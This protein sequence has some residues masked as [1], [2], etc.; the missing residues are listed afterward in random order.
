L[1]IAE[2]L[3]VAAFGILCI[4]GDNINAPWLLFEAGALAKKL[5]NPNVCPY[6]IH[7]KP[8]D[9]Q[10]PLSQFQACEATKAETRKLVHSINRAMSQG[11]LHEDQ[12]DRSFEKWWDDL[13]RALAE[14]Q[15]IET[16]SPLRTEKDLLEELIVRVRRLDNSLLSKSFGSYNAEYIMAGDNSFFEGTDIEQLLRR[17]SELNT[18]TNFD[19][20]TEKLHDGYSHSEIDGMWSTAWNGGIVGEKWAKGVAIVHVFRGTFYAITDDSRA[21]CLIGA[22]MYLNNRMWGR[23]LNLENTRELLPWCGVIRSNNKIDGLWDQGRWNFWQ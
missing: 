16:E 12:I 6:L 14:L 8:S 17:N 9:L 23:Y 7:L 4:T 18:V 19:I 13:E 3:E 22:R 21:V 1:E 2:K 11:A 5:S 20:E 10:G 15:I